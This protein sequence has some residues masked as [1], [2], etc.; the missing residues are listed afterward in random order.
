MCA[1]VQQ[2]CREGN[3]QASRIHSAHVSV[4][5]D[6]TASSETPGCAVTSPGALYVCKLIL[7]EGPNTLKNF[8]LALKNYTD[9]VTFKNPNFTLSF[10][11]F[12]KE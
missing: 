7:I 2:G 5:R 12:R 6:G 4:F 10:V 1:E 9:Q 3:V 11:M 8:T